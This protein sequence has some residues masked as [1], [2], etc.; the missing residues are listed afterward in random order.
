VRNLRG[1]C[2]RSSSRSSV[3]VVFSSS[4]SRSSDDHHHYPYVPFSRLMQLSSPRHFLGTTP[5]PSGSDTVQVRKRTCPRPA[6]IADGS[7]RLSRTFSRYPI[8]PQALDA[9]A[10]RWP[11][12]NVGQTYSQT[13]QMGLV[14]CRLCIAMAAVMPSTISGV[15]PVQGLDAGQHVRK[16]PAKR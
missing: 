9:S 1:G 6:V 7:R 4:P 15:G 13:K 8:K 10:R 14:R 12:E 11:T 2:C 5:A 3:A 16:T